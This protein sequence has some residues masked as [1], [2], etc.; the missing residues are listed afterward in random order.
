MKN[1]TP[2]ASLVRDYVPGELISVPGIYR[3][4][5]MDVYQGQCCIGPSI[6]SGG[7]R[8]IDSKNPKIFYRDWSGNPN[9]KEKK[10]VAHFGFGRAV[11]H[12]AAGETAFAE[13]FRVRPT[14]WDS[15]RTGDAKK[16]RAAQ[17][18]A[19]FTVLTPEDVEAIR[20]VAASLNEHPTIMAGILQ[21]L[22]EHSIFWKDWKTGVWLKARPDVIPVD[23][24]MIVD[25]KTAADASAISCR[26]SIA[27]FGYHIQM[28]MIDA[29][30]Q[31]TANFRADAFVDLFVEKDDPWCINH[32]PISAFA[33]QRGH[34]QLRRGV[35]GFAWCLKNDQWP[36][37]DDDEVEAELPKWYLDR[38]KYE[39]EHGLL[40]K[41]SECFPSAEDEAI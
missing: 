2:I 21:G 39:E 24:A 30:L 28:A 5:P 4:V 41:F 14:E 22:I 37:Y 34:Q 35:D 16:W 15:W 17:E 31:A 29:G 20:G 36:G 12:L 9:R 38:L 10:E 40:P 18:L 13:Q 1:P 27:D 7:V 6:S 23:S 32:K 19:K 3:N 25:L 26:R 33:M 8:T 11:H